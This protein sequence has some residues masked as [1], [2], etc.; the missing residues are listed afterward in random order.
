MMPSISNRS[1]FL[2]IMLA[3]TLCSAGCAGLT[4]ADRLVKA[5]DLLEVDYTCRLS[6]GGIL[7][8]T[9][10]NVALDDDRK[11]ARVFEYSPQDYQPVLMRAGGAVAGVG[12]SARD[13]TF[14]G[15]IAARLSEKVEGLRVGQTQ[16]VEL[17]DALIPG[18][19]GDNRYLTM[20]RV[21]RYG[22]FETVTR[23]E[24]E[25]S[26][27]K[28]P[29]I[30]TRVSWRGPFTARVDKVS[31]HF[32]GVQ[33]EAAPGTEMPNPFGKG[34]IEDTGDRFEVRVQAEEGALVRSANML[35]RIVE[36]GDELFKVDFGYHFGNEPLYCDVQVKAAGREQSEA[37]AALEA[38]DK[39]G[40]AAD[41][42]SEAKETSGSVPPRGIES[43]PAPPAAAAVE[44]ASGQP[45]PGPEKGEIESGNPGMVEGGD[46]VQVHF[47]ARLEEGSL[48][49][50]TRHELVND[51]QVRKAPGYIPSNNFA[52]S[53]LVAGESSVFPGL[54]DSLLGMTAGEKKTV[55]LVPDKAFGPQ[56]PKKIETFEAVRRIPLLGKV[57]A[58]DYL[59]R[60]G[61]IPVKG[62]E[63][64]FTPYFKS[65][66]VEVSETHVTLEA[67][68][69]DGATF[70]GAYGETTVSL[71]GDEA[72]IRLVPE[73][74]SSF[75]AN[76][77]EGKIAAFSGDTFS[78][79]F[80]PPLAGKAIVLEVEALSVTK[81]A[82][83]EGMSIQWIEDFNEGLEEAEK[84]GKPTVLVLYADWCVYSKKL[85]NET[86][87]DPR[88]KMLID[89][90]VWVKIDSDK[91]KGVGIMFEQ[92]GF[93]LTVILDSRGE[94]LGKIDG[95][96][97]A[98][99]FGAELN[100]A[101]NGRV[102]S[103]NSGANAS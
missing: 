2:C 89:E 85:F 8:T 93:P 59:Q 72:V 58:K 6:D 15:H 28:A 86:L 82:E 83:L 75:T 21:W 98:D 74:G 84:K 73:I 5:G 66:V 92:N 79:D 68:A 71:E 7:D 81:A 29:E 51:P 53:S 94:E 77:R 4:R 69:E 18:L 101:L 103:S 52:P 25:E 64:Q 37:Y 3:I 50:T 99:M 1:A 65:R 70:S 63:V 40:A 56:D 35:G 91:E 31:E 67:L 38:S 11:K 46:L 55:A 97:P 24:F 44:A 42:I 80:N 14:K 61:T 17:Q 23:E 78:V 41:G 102:A 60:F 33:L 12:Q 16:R 36:V 88:I 90:F 96:R 62:K 20:A 95:F 76:N 39:T 48:V 34:V 10:E 49:Q 22:K 26:F 43:G 100:K 30:G 87:V 9:V 13:R 54:G 57:S 27:Q 19:E 45:A 32:V 47:T